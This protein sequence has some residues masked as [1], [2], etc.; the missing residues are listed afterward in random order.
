MRVWAGFCAGIC[1]MMLA[2]LM[3]QMH[4][5]D[6]GYLPLLAAFGLALPLKA[7]S[8]LAKDDDPEIRRQ[9]R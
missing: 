8:D 2:V 6:M 1:F 9:R 5:S 4:Q 3:I 7:A